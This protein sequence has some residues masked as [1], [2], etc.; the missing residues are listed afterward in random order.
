[1]KKTQV[2]ICSWAHTPGYNFLDFEMSGKQKN[3]LM[4]ASTT[5]SANGN[6]KS[7]VL[8]FYKPERPNKQER[9]RVQTLFR[10]ELD[11]VDIHIDVIMIVVDENLVSSLENIVRS[12]SYREPYS[13]YQPGDSARQL[14]TYNLKDNQYASHAG[15]LFMEQSVSDEFVFSN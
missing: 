6:L 13:L 14:M 4:T 7:K 12:P 3:T 5:R 15:V 9:E 11:C 1:M 10:R 2:I 8:F